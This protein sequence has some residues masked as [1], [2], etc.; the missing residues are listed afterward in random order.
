MNDRICPLGAN[1]PLPDTERQNGNQGEKINIQDHKTADQTEAWFH[2]LLDT[3]IDGI[4]VTDDNGYI[5][6]FNKACEELFGYSA[7]EIMGQ[8]ISKIMPRSEAAHHGRHLTRY[9]ET[10]KKRIIGIGREL[11]A[12]RRDGSEFPIELSIGEANT[13]T[14]RQ[15]IGIIR[16]ISWRKQSEARQRQL[17]HDLEHLARLSAMTELGA[18]I[19]HELNQP[20]TAIMLY[21]QAATRNAGSSGLDDDTRGILEKAA[22][23]A[24]RAGKILRGMR[25]FIEK[26]E[27]ERRAV[28][29]HEVIHEAVDLMSQS[30]IDKG[31]ELHFSL[32][33]KG[34]QVQVNAE[35]VQ[36]QQI[37]VN[38]VRNAVD[39]LKQAAEKKILIE[40]VIR[41]KMVEIAVEDSGPGLDEDILPNLFRAFSASQNGGMGLGLAISRS[42]AR[43]HDG[44]LT[45]AA[46]QNGRGA[47][48]VLTL[49][50][51]GSTESH[52]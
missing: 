29:I 21:M 36:I 17:Q 30:L 12:R 39:A 6:A 5:L 10:G 46:P 4:I 1:H 20:L 45:T 35:P 16:D 14:G 33:E 11:N 23:E 37:L 47:R 22:S 3:A 48:F 13:N 42:I 19:A 50:L 24:E 44:E 34:G 25:R 40:T 8:G 43:R 51:I 38:L 32:D 49:P 27:V 18:A 28:S 2:S 7:S 26:G 9:L 15:F 52:G 31:I 41:D